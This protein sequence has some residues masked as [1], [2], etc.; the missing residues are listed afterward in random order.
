ML[1]KS[2]TSRA[3][4]QAAI[5]LFA[6]RGF[7]GVTTREIASAVGI[8]Q[9]SLYYYYRSKDG[10]W[11]DVVRYVLDILAA[12]LIAITHGNDLPETKL[13]NF[14]LSAMFL[15]RPDVARIIDLE[16]DRYTRGSYGMMSDAIRK[17][18]SLLSNLV[19][20]IN[21]ECNS[22]LYVYFFFGLVYGTRKQRSMIAQIPALQDLAEGEAL[23][24]ALGDWALRILSLESVPPRR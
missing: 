1:E 19:S 15:D 13:R 18:Q 11:D 24:I 14:F 5:K 20:D 2:E 23:G 22:E 10:I 3:I 12:D 4:V 6:D 21:A 9:A 8:K 17:T 7:D 16:L